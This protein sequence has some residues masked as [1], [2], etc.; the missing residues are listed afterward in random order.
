MLVSLSFMF[1]REDIEE[2]PELQ[3][4]AA[5]LHQDVKAMEHTIGKTL[6]EQQEELHP[7]K[8]QVIW[9]IY[10]NLNKAFAIS[11]VVFRH[12]CYNTVKC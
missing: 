4:E 11:L 3:R 7:L 10:K 8:S 12:K 6:Q 1:I 5:A 2:N 9:T